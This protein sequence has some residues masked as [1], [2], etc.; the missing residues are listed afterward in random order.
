MYSQP[1]LPPKHAGPVYF[2]VLGEEAAYSRVNERR[3]VASTIRKVQSSGA[4]YR[5]FSDMGLRLV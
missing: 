2:I 4:A 5:R 3:G 1:P